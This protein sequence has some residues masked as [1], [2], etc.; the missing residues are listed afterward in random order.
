MIHSEIL[1]KELFR[2][3][4]QLWPEKFQNKTN[5]VTLRRWVYGS[6]RRLANLITETLGS[7]EWLTDGQLLKGLTSHAEDEQFQMVWLFFTRVVRNGEKK[8]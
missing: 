1:K 6:N 5:G 3:F 7:E 2:D 4:Y 8:T